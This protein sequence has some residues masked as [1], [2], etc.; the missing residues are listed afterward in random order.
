[1]TSAY[2]VDPARI[3]LHGHGTGGRLAYLTA[4]S[5][6]EVV[7]AVAAVDA[8]IAG[9]PPEHDPLYPVAFFTAWAKQSPDADR[10]EASVRRLRRMKYPV[11]IKPLGDEARHLSAEESSELVRWID[12]LDRI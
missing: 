10:I 3:V 1:V 6:P 5:G 7:R 4:F 9:R 8:P 11:T 12:M 2:T